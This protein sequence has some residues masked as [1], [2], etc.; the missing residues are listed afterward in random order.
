[1]DAP[2]SDVPKNMSFHLSSAIMALLGYRLVAVYCDREAVDHRKRARVG[3][4]VQTGN[5]T[6]P[7][8]THTGP[9]AQ[10]SLYAADAFFFFCKDVKFL[11]ILF[12]N[13]K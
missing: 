10:S 3:S 4:G 12:K 5:S 9:T 13:P 6:P 11:H 7:T 8:S 2:F 1:M